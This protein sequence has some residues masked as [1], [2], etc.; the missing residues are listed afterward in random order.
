[1]PAL[2]LMPF[3]VPYE[4]RCESV[5]WFLWQQQLDWTTWP[6]GSDEEAGGWAV[7]SSRCPT[8]AAFSL[9]TVIRRIHKPALDGPRDAVAA[10]QG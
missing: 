2:Q 8:F 9:S 10:P 3:L 6:E 4:S 7:D 1:M 5:V